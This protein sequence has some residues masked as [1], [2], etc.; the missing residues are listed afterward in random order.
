MTFEEERIVAE[1]MFYCLPWMRQARARIRNLETAL[2]DGQ[3]IA[4]SAPTSGDL[5][6]EWRGYLNRWNDRV[7]ALLTSNNTG[8]DHG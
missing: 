7:H 4:T 5:A 2:R 1:G 3:T 8:V 6:D